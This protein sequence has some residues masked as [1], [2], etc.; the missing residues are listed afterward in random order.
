[1]GT[2]IKTMRLKNVLAR[3]VFLTGYRTENGQQKIF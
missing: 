3:F 2:Y 1:M